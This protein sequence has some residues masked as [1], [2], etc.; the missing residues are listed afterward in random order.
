MSFP[1]D[2]SKPLTVLH[3][4][5]Q[6]WTVVT[7]G[8]P[9]LGSAPHLTYTLAS[10]LS[11]STFLPAHIIH[12]FKCQTIVLLITQSLL[13]PTHLVS[14]Q[15]P[16]AICISIASQAPKAVTWLSIHCHQKLSRK[17]LGHCLSSGWSPSDMNEWAMQKVAE[18]LNQVMQF[19]H[20]NKKLASCEKL[21]SIISQPFM[22]QCRG[23]RPTQWVWMPFCAG[24]Y[25]AM[26]CGL[27]SEKHLMLAHISLPI[28]QE[29][30]VNQKPC[31]TQ[32]CRLRSKGGGE[33]MLW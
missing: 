15:I 28:I 32:P 24:C 7:L 25:S 21:K 30:F 13:G 23:L 27:T 14:L 31:D 6:V 11:A 20:S 1:L 26:P 10:R 19:H 22:W 33:W 12:G 18:L 17:H 2:A 3:G 4:K 8:D 9:L 29:M 16:V 5:C